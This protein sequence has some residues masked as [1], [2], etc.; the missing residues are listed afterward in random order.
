[1]NRMSRLICCVDTKIGESLS[2]F[3]IR[4]NTANHYLTPSYIFKSIMNR[5]P[6]KNPNIVDNSDGLSRLEML[7]GKSLNVLQE[8]G[9]IKQACNS[10]RLSSSQ[11]IN[12]YLIQSHGTKICPVCLILYGYQKKIWELTLVTACTEHEV[13]LLDKCPKCNHHFQWLR[14]EILKCSCGQSLIDIETTPLHKNEVVLS[15]LVASLYAGTQLVETT[16]CFP[17]KNLDIFNIAKLV[18]FIAGMLLNIADTTGKSIGTINNNSQ[19]HEIMSNTINVFLNWPNAFYSLLDRVRLNWNNKGYNGIQKDFGSFHKLITMEFS[20]DKLKFLTDSFRQYLYN[21][22]GGYITSKNKIKDAKQKLVSQATASERLGVSPITVKRLL[23]EGYISGKISEAGMRSLI[24]VDPVSVDE[25]LNK[26]DATYSLN[27]AAEILGIGHETTANLLVKGCL[28]AFKGPSVDGSLIWRV[29]KDSI[30]KLLHSCEL[31][32]SGE[33]GPYL[34]F[35]NVVRKLSVYG[36]SISCIISKTLEGIIVPSSLGIEKVGLQRLRYSSHRIDQYIM[37]LKSQNK[38]Y[39]T[40]VD[41][42]LQLNVKQQVISFWIDKGFIQAIKIT[43]KKVKRLVEQFQIE[44]FKSHYV[45]A[46]EMAKT[47]GISSGRLIKNYESIGIYPVSGPSIDQGRQYLYLID[48]IDNH[49]KNDKV[50]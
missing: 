15:S 5:Y 44:Y 36:V 42:S 3:I 11:D 47:Q 6:S 45:I 26:L 31:N 50:R 20:G 32:L 40:V 35:N 10:Y 28:E 34:T 48:D 1:M 39:L 21:W 14:R 27:D 38:Q 13:I 46:S 19:R 8:M 23:K 33:I 25:Y 4:L 41:I 2:S 24:L 37:E 9:F 29:N 22:D 7:S 49:Y 30:Y 12:R 17:L 18:F 43:G 16:E